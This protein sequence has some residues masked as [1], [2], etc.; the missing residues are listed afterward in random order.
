MPT[1]LP[2]RPDQLCIGLYIRLDPKNKGSFSKNEFLITEERQIKQLKKLGL[3]FLRVV[4][5]KSERMPL[6][7]ED[8]ESE[9]GN[10]GASGETEPESKT[11]VSKE[12]LGLK[13][14][15]IE[16]NR[17]RKRRYAACERRYDKTMIRV[18][19]VLRRISAHSEAAV[20]EAKD[21]VKDIAGPFLSDRDTIIN[22]MSSRS[23][24]EQKVM[25]SLNV[26]VL[27]LMIGSEFNLDE[28]QML[29]LGLGALL[30]DIGKGRIPMNVIRGQTLDQATAKYYREHPAIG[31]R[32]ISE[33]T[34]ISRQAISIVHQH[35]E[36]VDGSGYPQGLKSDKISSLSKIVALVNIYDNLLNAPNNGKLTPHEAVKAVYRRYRSKLDE[37]SLKV[38]IRGMGVYPPG[39][40]VELS[41]GVVGIVTATNPKNAARP[42]VLI[43]HPDVPKKEALMVDLKIEEDLTVERSIKPEDL[44]REIFNYLRPST[45]V[46]YYADTV[47][48]GQ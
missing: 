48:D 8:R 43:Y 10:A 19:T 5:E 12:L 32:L 46:N 36:L 6:P 20:S 38:F 39:T 14:E 27:S 24:E 47:P 17:E 25:H 4:L 34:G 18:S 11:P 1:E 30:H 33:F 22:L 2:V 26:A 9:G 31:V 21:V 16:R 23:G 13:K 45:T 15:T 40:V 7:P 28:K 42:T 37:K 41:N 3:P 29:I 44:P 35:H